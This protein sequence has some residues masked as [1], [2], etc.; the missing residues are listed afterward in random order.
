MTNSQ[1]RPWVA[2][3]VWSLLIVV[4]DV[5]VDMGITSSQLWPKAC[6]WGMVLHSQHAVA[7]MVHWEIPRDA[8]VLEPESVWSVDIVHTCWPY[9][10]SLGQYWATI[11]R[12]WQ[13]ISYG[14]ILSDLH[15]A[16]Q[17]LVFDT[18]EVSPPSC[19]VVHSLVQQTAQTKSYGRVG[20]LH[21]VVAAQLSRSLWPG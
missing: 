5:A 6:V 2:K 1:G 20:L 13:G 15:V 9:L 11:R 3:M 12:T 10:V 7:P 21:L 4:C 18:S 16:L 17:W 19:L 8:T 14:C